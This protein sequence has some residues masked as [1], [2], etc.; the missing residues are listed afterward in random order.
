MKKMYKI[1]DIIDIN[2]V[3]AIKNQAYIAAFDS[4]VSG[5]KPFNHKQYERDKQYIKKYCK[6][7]I[8]ELALTAKR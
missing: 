1:G 3:N 2:D 8:I 7:K 6:F 4:M 5:G